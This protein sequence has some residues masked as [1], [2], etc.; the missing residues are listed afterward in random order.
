MGL[1]WNL[2]EKTLLG[3]TLR[4]SIGLMKVEDMR[5]RG[6]EVLRKVQR[7]RSFLDSFVD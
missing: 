2:R 4:M 3:L 6:M 1:Q 7:M 5:N